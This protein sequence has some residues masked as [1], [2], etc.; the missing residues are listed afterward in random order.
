MA[1]VI[2]AQVDVTKN[3]YALGEGIKQVV[4]AIKESCA[5]GWQP[6]QD[7]PEIVIKSITALAPVIGGITQLDNEATENTEEF[8]TGLMLKGKEIAFMFTKKN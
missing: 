2:Q 1:E 7:L 6:D 8:V 4:K 3:G 5:D